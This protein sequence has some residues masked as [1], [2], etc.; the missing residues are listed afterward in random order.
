MKSYTQLNSIQI[1]RIVK[2]LRIANLDKSVK[3]NSL[4][5]E[6]E[7]DNL[8]EID[9]KIKP[10]DKDKV[11]Y[12]N[13]QKGNNNIRLKGNKGTYFTISVGDWNRLGLENTNGH[14]VFNSNL[15]SSEIQ[16]EL[17]YCLQDEKF[18]YI[19]KKLYSTAGK[20]S[21]QSYANQYDKLYKS[22]ADKSTPFDEL[23]RAV[24]NEIIERP[25][26][27]KKK[28]QPNEKWISLSKIEKSKLYDKKYE[29][30]ILHTF[31]SD[32]T[33]I[34]F[35]IENILIGKKDDLI[36]EVI[37]QKSLRQILSLEDKKRIEL[38]AMEY[39][40]NK[41][42][43]DDFNMI[44][45]SANR[46]EEWGYDFEANEKYYIEVKGTTIQGDWN[47]IMTKNEYNASEKHKKKYFLCIVQFDNKE[48]LN[49]VNYEEIQYPSRG[50]N[51]Q[52]EPYTYT[53]KKK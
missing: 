4:E 26:E 37:A 49:V 11:I 47:I 5:L 46:G 51:L 41:W 44:D 2:I 22:N 18:I 15:S 29:N 6:T 48:D 7:F 42:E 35:S 23:L 53:V 31:L 45:V 19:V 8:T 39:V 12:R 28:N 3:V 36:E 21:M 52:I 16:I 50:E 27:G 24:D 1:D 33:N 40:K 17:G 13:I 34:L 9:D 32:I 30:E 10:E 43:D 14:I 25:Y 20:G 38:A